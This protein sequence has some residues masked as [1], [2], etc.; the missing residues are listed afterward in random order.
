MKDTN[1]FKVKL[2]N[3]KKLLEE[4]MGKIAR[5]NPSNPNDWEAV[6]DDLNHDEADEDEVANE[7][8]T[9][10]ENSSVLNKL[11]AQYN[12]VKDAL[13]KIKKGTYGICEVSGEDIPEERLEAN[14]AARTCVKHAK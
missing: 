2:E 7:I 14:P 10:D 9:L 6:E 5:K 12:D 4:E 3:E 8:E 13:E 11:E 1:K